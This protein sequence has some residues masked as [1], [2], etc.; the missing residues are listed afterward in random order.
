M[1]R[2]LTP[3]TFAELKEDFYTA[4]ERVQSGL[5][6]IADDV[7]IREAFGI[8]RLLR[9]CDAAQNLEC[10]CARVVNSYF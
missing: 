8:M 4:L 6:A 7:K 3:P 10:Q 5:N 2:N 1:Q 9:T